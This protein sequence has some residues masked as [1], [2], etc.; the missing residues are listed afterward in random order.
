MH[1]LPRF[2]MRMRLPECGSAAVNLVPVRRGLQLRPDV[3]RQGLPARARTSGREAVMHAVRLAASLSKPLTL[4]EAAAVAG[5]K[6]SS[7]IVVVALA[8][9]MVS[10][11]PFMA[12]SS[13][14]PAVRRPGLAWLLRR[15][16]ASHDVGVAG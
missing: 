6:S 3:Q 10:S 7:W 15:K 4:F 1:G 5:F 11:M 8:G 13:R 12:M 9:P 16:R 2:G 14:T